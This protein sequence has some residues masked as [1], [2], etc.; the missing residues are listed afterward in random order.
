MIP[1]ITSANHRLNRLGPEQKRGRGKGEGGRRRFILVR[2]FECKYSPIEVA[3]WLEDLADAVFKNVKNV[4]QVKSNRRLAIDLEIQAGLGR[5]F[6][7]K[8]RK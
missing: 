3:Q 6:A 5:F 7:A 2:V 4:A 1:G 8:F